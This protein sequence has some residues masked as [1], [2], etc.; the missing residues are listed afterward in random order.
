MMVC[1]GFSPRNLHLW[2]INLKQCNTGLKL[3]LL[4][5]SPEQN[6]QGKLLTRG[7]TG[8]KTAQTECRDRW[9]RKVCLR[10]GRNRWRLN[11]RKKRADWRRKCWSLVRFDHPRSTSVHPY[12]F[13]NAVYIPRYWGG[14]RNVSVHLFSH[15]TAVQTCASNARRSRACEY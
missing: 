3:Q 4:N 13:T 1:P 12:L 10:H 5:K 7:T 2:Y 8:V 11:P 14:K 6:L 15:A 9:G